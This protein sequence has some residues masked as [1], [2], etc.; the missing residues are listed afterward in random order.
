[1]S[2]ALLLLITAIIAAYAIISLIIK[3]DKQKR[4][5]IFLI[6]SAIILLIFLFIRINYLDLVV[7]AKD[8]Y[9]LNN[10]SWADFWEK[11]YEPFYKIFNFLVGRFTNDPKILFCI[12]DIIGLMGPLFFIYKNSKNKLLSILIYISIGSFAINQSALRQVLAVSIVTFSFDFVIKKKKIPFLLSIIFASLF[13]YT[14]ITALLIYPAY[15]WNLRKISK[16]IFWPCIFIVSTLIGSLI[17]QIIMQF[18]K[19]KSYADT[20][21]IIGNTGYR[22]LVLYIVIGLTIY[23]LLVYLCKEKA[24]ENEKRLLNVFMLCIT[25]QILATQVAIMNRVTSYFVNTLIVLIPNSIAIIEDRKRRTIIH[26]STFV[27]TIGLTILNNNFNSYI[28]I[29]NPPNNNIQGPS[30]Q[31]NDGEKQ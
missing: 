12:I 21:F 18:D 14:A 31:I 3:K 23:L 10:C 5:V 30:N 9:F 17:M 20:E 6:L 22:L 7:Y 29:F 19:Y 24:T 2:I 15:N 28:T 8:F 25:F 13:H 4:D 1:M 16:K 11:A 26:V 27:A